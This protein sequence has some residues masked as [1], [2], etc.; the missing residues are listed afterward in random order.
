MQN[1]VQ[2]LL[3]RTTFKQAVAFRAYCT[4]KI[5][6]I[7]QPTASSHPQLLN[8]GEI[9]PG[10]TAEEYITRRKRLLEL[11]P[12]NGLAIIAAAPV[13]MM[14]DVVPYT[15]R[16]DADY[17]YI[18]GCLQPGGLAVMSHEFGLCMF[19]PETKPYDVLWQGKIAGVDAALEFFKA[20][21]AYPMTKLR[22]ILPDIIRRSSKLFHN[23][24]TATSTYLDLEAFRKAAENNC[25]KDIS[26]F[27][28]ELRLIKST[29]EQ[30]LMRDSASIACQA[31]LQTMIHSKTYPHESML[32]AKV[33]YECRMR[34]AQRMAFN[35][36]VGGG[37]NGSVIHYSRND[38]KVRDGDFVLMDVGCELHGYVSDLTRTWPPCG[39]FSATQE[40][41]YEL[42]LQTNKEC[43]KL[44]KPGATIL[45]IHNY[46]VETLRKGFKELGILQNWKSDFYHHLNPT[47]IGHYLGM[48]VHDCARVGYDRPL[49]PGNNN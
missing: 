25:V 29:A 32:S 6:D 24:N 49:K 44:C 22:E 8:E 10:I 47:S 48:D 36:V 45:E 27:T 17:L 46:S 40:E 26:L 18:T 33:E 4:N 21:Q 20:D 11:L 37:C 15:F 38:Q 28:H 2:K 43:I 34:G 42:I 31:L 39:K 12:Q 7:G 1:L 14:T 41:L 9:T 13:K 3:P 16:Q 23:S 5:L 19:M 30:K 35:P